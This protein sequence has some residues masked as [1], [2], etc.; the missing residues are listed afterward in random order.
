MKI[1]TK[2]PDIANFQLEIHEKFSEFSNLPMWKPSRQ[3]IC[4][5][6]MDLYIHNAADQCCQLMSKKGHSM[7]LDDNN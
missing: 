5:E 7:K 4:L 2:T 1:S 3:Y 6:K